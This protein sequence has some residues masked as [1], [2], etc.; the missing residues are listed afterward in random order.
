MTNLCILCEDEYV[1]AAR[2]R[3]LSTLP[4]AGN[5]SPSELAYKKAKGIDPESR[6]NHLR[7]GCSPTGEAPAT[8]WFCFITVDE[9]T[10][11]K[12]LAKQMYTIIE[13]DRIPSAFLA[14]YGLKRIRS[15]S[16]SF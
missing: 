12:M 9:E 10:R 5:L 7:I 14:D 3:L 8:H 6:D 13:G 1:E 15:K 16:N 11:Q 2:K 4:N